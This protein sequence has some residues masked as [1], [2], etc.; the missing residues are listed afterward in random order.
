MCE[1][2][3]LNYKYYSE[4]EWRIVCPHDFNKDSNTL[5]ATCRYFININGDLNEE[6]KK[7]G[8]KVLLEELKAYLSKNK[9][10]KLKYL[11]P[12]DYWLS[13]I[14]YPSP[15]IKIIAENDPEIRILIRSLKFPIEE[16]SYEK[17]TDEGI[18]KRNMIVGEKLMM[19]MEIDLDTIGH[20]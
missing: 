15:V 5:R 19:P 13:V 14:V 18:S 12:M 17:L 4:S 6:V 16:K 1:S 20:F 9:S 3:D 8:G 2:E 10:D 11:M 7:Y